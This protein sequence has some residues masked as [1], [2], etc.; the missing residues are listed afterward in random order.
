MIR[1][2]IPSTITAKKASRRLAAA[3]L[4]PSFKTTA[5]HLRFRPKSTLTASSRNMIV[6]RRNNQAVSKRQQHKKS[7]LAISGKNNTTTATEQ[8]SSQQI[9]SIFLSAA[10]PMVGFGF[11]DNFVMITAGQAIDNSLGV[12]MGLAT[13][14][15]YRLCID[16]QCVTRKAK[17][18]NSRLFLFKLLQTAAAMGQVVSDVSGVMFGDTL[19]RLFKVSS[20]QL[21]ASQ[22][23]LAAVHRLRLAGAVLGVIAGC[24]LGAT[25]LYIVPD[26]NNQHDNGSSAAIMENSSSSNSVHH[27]QQKE[28]QIKEQLLYRLQKVL[29]DVMTNQE[30]KWYSRDARCTLYVNETLSSCIPSNSDNS[31]KQYFGKNK[32]IGRGSPA[33]IDRLDGGG[34]NKDEKDSAAIIRSTKESRCIVFTNTIYVPVLAD[35]NISDS[36]I[37]GILKVELQNGSFYSGSEIKDAKRVARNLGF[38]MNHMM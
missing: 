19:A 17:E 37:L 15:S 18:L 23:K 30:E 24:T 3:R 36:N 22:R 6:I 2:I 13:M 9:R 14:V 35:N 4:S 32:V 11:M 34:E 29:N 25:A 1:A 10:I 12:Q 27:Q 31:L 20:A 8:L 16:L 33:I 38:F 28:V 21:S 26:R 5:D 7:T